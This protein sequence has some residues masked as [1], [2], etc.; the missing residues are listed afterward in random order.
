MVA[1]GRELQDFGPGD[2]AMFDAEAFYAE[3][4]AG[5]LTAA[6]GNGSILRYEHIKDTI[7]QKAVELEIPAI[8][9]TEDQLV[10]IRIHAARLA[11]EWKDLPVGEKLTLAFVES[12]EFY[13]CKD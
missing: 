7:D 9:L 6:E 4:L 5:L 2:A 12:P 13:H 8:A 11:D 1:S 3:M 10:N